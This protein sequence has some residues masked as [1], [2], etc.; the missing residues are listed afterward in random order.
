MIFLLQN[1]PP[2]MHMIIATRADPPF[3]L[4]RLRERGELAGAA[5]ARP[6]FPQLKTR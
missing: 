4:S 1:I 2:R 6:S 3:P 5:S